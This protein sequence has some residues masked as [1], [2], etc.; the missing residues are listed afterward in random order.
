MAHFAKLSEENVVLNIVTLDNKH[1][2]DE[3]NN[4]SEAVG[5]AYLAKHNN[6]PANLWK[7]YS[8]Y[9]VNNQHQQSGTPFRG[10][11]ANIG[12]IW[13]PENEI[14]MTQKPFPSWTL[15][16]AEAKW[17]SP[18]GDAPD[19]DHLWNEDTQ[20]WYLPQFIR[21]DTE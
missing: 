17:K 5:Q 16:L 2:L 11:A 15:D 14:F 10:N 8:Y 21:I 12:G 1:M 19:R 4:E 20:S 3:N 13:D 7:Q 9:T 6:W 18:A